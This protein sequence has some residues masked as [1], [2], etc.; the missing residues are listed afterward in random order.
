MVA[1]PGIMIWIGLCAA[2]LVV[3][4]TSILLGTILYLRV[5]NQRRAARRELH[6][7]RWRPLFTEALLEYPTSMPELTAEE[8]VEVLPL[9]VYFNESVA[10]DARVNLAQAGR[11]CGIDLHAKEALRH[12]SVRQRLMAIQAVGH[13]HDR[14]LRRSLR[15]LTRSTNPYISL[16]AAHALLRINPREA[17]PLILPLIASRADWSPARVL[18][19]LREAGADVV[20][21][22]LV[23]TIQR[24]EV[25][26]QPLL[27]LYLEAA[28]RRAAVQ[29][30]KEILLATDDQQ[31]ITTGIYQLGHLAHPDG[32]YVV[33]NHLDHPNWRVQLHAITAVGRLGTYKDVAMLAGKLASERYWVRYRAAQAIAKLPSVSSQALV[34]LQGAQVDRFAR[35]ILAQ[36]IDEMGLEA[37]AA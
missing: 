27:M 16:A 19:L 13:L 36:V 28:E 25:A 4:C 37:I 5:S 24:A 26:F 30:I 3:L 20:T 7:G 34:A 10:G 33:R 1:T 18:A 2:V 22:P 35:D 6:V 11:L 29:V 15:P 9:W 32:L 8:A 17:L 12:G 21:Q 23:E 14:D 31:V